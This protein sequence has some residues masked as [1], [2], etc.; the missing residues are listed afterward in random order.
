MKKLVYISLLLFC[1]SALNAQDAKPT[2]TKN[3]SFFLLP[4]SFD[5]NGEAAISYE[6]EELLEG[7]E[8]A[9]TAFKK[10]KRKSGWRMGLFITGG[11]LGS[12]PIYKSILGGEPDYTFLF[13]GAGL[14]YGG[15]LLFDGAINKS[16]DE[17]ISIYDGTANNN[18]SVA[19]LSFGIQKTGIGLKLSF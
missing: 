7:N 1:I 5:I 11:L 16:V 19:K 6:V 13:A 18:G 17:V 4:A 8:L 2:L 15:I 14:M 9:M 3:P 10:Y 12:Y